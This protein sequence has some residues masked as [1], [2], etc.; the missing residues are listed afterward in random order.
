MARANTAIA[1]ALGMTPAPRVEPGAFDTEL[2]GT[3]PAEFVYR[4]LVNTSLDIV[5]G[6]RDAVTNHASHMAHLHEIARGKR[7]RGNLE[8]WATNTVSLRGGRIENSAAH[9]DAGKTWRFG[10][11]QQQLTDAVNYFNTEGDTSIRLTSATE[12]SSFEVGSGEKAEVWL[13]SATVPESRD[14]NPNRLIHSELV[15]EYLVDAKPVLA[16]CDE[17]TGREV[18]ATELPFTKPTNAG[19]RS[20]STAAAFPPLTEL[21]YIADILLGGSS[22]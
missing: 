7:V 11:Y 14:G 6:T 1:K 3:R 13:I 15:F 19:L 21:C 22:K 5:S 10:A 2:I 18:P 20:A 12:A 17:A 16:E 4:N 8:K 9:P